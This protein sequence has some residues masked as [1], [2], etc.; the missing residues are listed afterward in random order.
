[1][2]PDERTIDPA[3]YEEHYKQQRPYERWQELNL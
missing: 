1:M 3:F 2:D